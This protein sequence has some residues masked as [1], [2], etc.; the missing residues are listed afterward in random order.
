VAPRACGAGGAWCRGAWR[1]GCVA[2][3]LR[4]A[5]AALRRGC[6]TARAWSLSA[7]VCRCARPGQRWGPARSA[8]PPWSFFVGARVLRGNPRAWQHIGGPW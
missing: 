5:A 8:T 3:R 7:G 1:R 6:V 2:P 4:D